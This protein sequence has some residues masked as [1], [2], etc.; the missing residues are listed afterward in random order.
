MTHW[1][2]KIKIRAVEIYINSTITQENIAKMFEINIRT[3]QKWL[4]EYRR[5]WSLNHRLISLIIS[6]IV[7]N[8][9]PKFYFYF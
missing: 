7:G 1:S 3:L 8:L 5:P 4:Y 2:S 6:S 9:Y